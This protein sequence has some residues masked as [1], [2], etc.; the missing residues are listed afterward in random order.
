MFKKK[1][2]SVILSAAVLC[3]VFLSPFIN[4][5]FSETSGNVY[6]DG[7]W[8]FGVEQFVRGL[9]QGCL[10]REP[11]WDGFSYWCTGLASGQVTGKEAAR[12]FFFS[13]EFRRIIPMLTEEEMINKFYNIFLGRNADPTGLSHWTEILRSGGSTDELFAGFADSQ[14]FLA[15]C[16]ACGVT[17]GPHISVPDMK[18]YWS[19]YSTGFNLLRLQRGQP[20]D[21][22]AVLNS[23]IDQC[24][25]WTNLEYSYSPDAMRYVFGGKNLRPGGGIDCSGFVTAIYKRAFGTQVMGFADSVYEPALYVS[26]H[27]YMGPWSAGVDR[28]PPFNEGMY[29]TNGD[30]ARPVFVDRYGIASAYAMNTYQWQFWL[31]SLGFTGH[32]Y[33]TW[34]IGEYSQ[35]ELNRM[36]SVRGFKPG[37][38]VMWYTSSV[39]ATHTEHIGIYAGNGYVWHCTSMIS[40]GI[41]YTPISFM[42][43]YRGTSIQF[44]RIYH[45]S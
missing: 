7:G 27:D 36:L 44:C 15:R 20:I 14:E 34:H 23:I 40:N 22:A 28:C 45:M 18:S 19:E 39:D 1:L 35:E 32:S 38:I 21:D 29:Y 3:S 4:T 43:S 33:L 24:T 31:D 41:Q 16:E 9:Y 2:L 30:A 8:S 6:A 13:S 11:E 37:D 26:S 25:Y 42:G 12:G 5:R 10:E 17:C